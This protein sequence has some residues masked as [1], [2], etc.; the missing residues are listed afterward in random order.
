MT[1]R[2][3]VSPRLSIYRVPSFGRARKE[4]L[5]AFVPQ[6]LFPRST[7]ILTVCYL[8]YDQA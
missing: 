8:E 6:T 1:C 5:C 7:P 2:V 4:R 3:L